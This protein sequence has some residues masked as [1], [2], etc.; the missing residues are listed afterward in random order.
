MKILAMADLHSNKI[1]LPDLTDIDVIMVA[2]DLTNT[3]DELEYKKIFKFLSALKKPVIY[4]LG[5]HDNRVDFYYIKKRY[6]TTDMYFLDNKIMEF[7]GYKIYGTPY[8]TYCGW[9]NHYF[10]LE[11]CQELTIPKEKVDII[12]CHEPPMIPELSD[13][14]KANN[15][16]LK[17]LHEKTGITV[18]SGHIHEKSGACIEINGNKCYNV[19]RTYQIIEV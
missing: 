1:S 6:E 19:A 2:G 11:E 12:L 15:E 4:V 14:F 18:I 3:G 5:N 8:S 10:T 17:Y 16:L 13:R 7:N 9:W